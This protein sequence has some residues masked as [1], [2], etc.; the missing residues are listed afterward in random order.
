MYTWFFYANKVANISSIFPTR[1]SFIPCSFC[2]ILLYLEATN[3]LYPSFLASEIRWS[4][5]E[6]GRISPAKPISAAKHTLG[7]IATS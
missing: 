1:S 4:I 6:T 7:E 2:V 5:L 3:V